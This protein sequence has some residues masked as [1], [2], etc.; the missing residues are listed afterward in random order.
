MSDKAISCWMRFQ[1]EIHGKEWRINIFQCLDFYWK[2]AFKWVYLSF[3][4]LPFASLLF[5]AI[6]EA[7]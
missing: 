6:C 7:S 2:S 5:T 1:P 4:P 3:S